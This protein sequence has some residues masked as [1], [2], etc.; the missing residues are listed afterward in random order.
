MWVARGW[1]IGGSG[2]GGPIGRLLVYIYFAKRTNTVLNLVVF[3]VP[4]P[5]P[6]AGQCGTA[7]AG[8]SPICSGPE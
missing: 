6:F 7:N 8:L 1:E 3:S 5:P 2:V 4:G